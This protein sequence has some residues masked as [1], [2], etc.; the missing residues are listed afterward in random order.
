MSKLRRSAVF[1]A[2]AALVFGSAVLLRPAGAAY[3]TPPVTLHAVTPQSAGVSIGVPFGFGFAAA[4]ADVNNDGYDDVIVA[5]PKADFGGHVDCGEVTVFRGPSLTDTILLHQPTPEDNSYFGW[6]VTAA[7]FNGDGF[8]DI[9]VGSPYAAVGGHP[10]AGR[11]AVFFGPSLTTNA[12]IDNPQPDNNAH[13]GSSLAVGDMNGDGKADLLVGAPDA[14]VG[15]MERAGK[16]F[17]F[18]APSF[19]TSYALQAPQPEANSS[20]GR[21]LAAADV[22][23]DGY[24]DVVIGAPDAGA[25]GEA[26]G[27]AF[28]FL[29]PSFGTVTTLHDPEP[30]PGAY[31]GQAVAGGDFNADGY[32]DLL[33]GAYGSYRWPYSGAGRAFI[34]SAPSL[35]SVTVL[36][37][38]DIVADSAYFGYELTVADV[39]HDGYADAVIGAHDADVTSPPATAGG[40][41]YIFLGPSFQT[42]YLFQEPQPEPF[43]FFS[44]SIAVGDVNGDGQGDLITGAPGAD[45]EGIVNAG[46]AFVF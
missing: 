39:N 10:A 35:N 36:E 4:A 19:S 6:S 38:P 15:G 12:V 1:L 30:E 24:D 18:V 27:L 37:Q 26:A 42:V 33:V 45:V 32:D 14:P 9:A 34:F 44:R 11:V 8:A 23:N 13:F 25:D 5:S 46:E 22:N 17:V 2:L 29:S 3:V 21:A 40:E 20:F 16:G 41:A 31:F 43:A 28:V 7:D